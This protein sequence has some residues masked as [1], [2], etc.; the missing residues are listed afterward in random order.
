A[1]LAST[2]LDH[3]FLNQF[4]CGLAVV[5]AAGAIEMA[6][7][8]AV[9]L[10]GLTFDELTHR[11]VADFATTTIRED[12]SIFPVEE[13]PVS[14]AL[15]TGQKQEPVTMG[16]SRADGRVTWATYA[17]SPIFGE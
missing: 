11:Y 12:G 9:K 10:L 13:Y 6:N 1:A 7:E 4:P 3:H 2:K 15:A 8:E 5:S 16:V 14:R 17:A